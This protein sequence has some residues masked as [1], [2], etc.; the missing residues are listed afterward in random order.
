MKCNSRSVPDR[1][2]ILVSMDLGNVRWGLIGLVNVWV[3]EEKTFRKVCAKFAPK[4][5]C[6]HT[7]ATKD[8]SMVLLLNKHSCLLIK[9][10]AESL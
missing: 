6:L 7:S 10:C 9:E 1:C 3:E 4:H 2:D 8:H 5:N